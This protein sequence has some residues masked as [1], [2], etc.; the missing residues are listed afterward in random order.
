MTVSEEPKE[1][2]GPEKVG[3][4]D[5]E[6]VRRWQIAYDHVVEP[7]EVNEMGVI[8]YGAFRPLFDVARNAL[9]ATYGYVEP[10]DL[11]R[12]NWFFPVVAYSL[13]IHGPARAGDTIEI[14]AWWHT[15]KGVRAWMGAEVYAKATGAL[16]ARG[17]TEHCFVDART[18]RPVRPDPGW[19]ICLRQ[20][21]VQSGVEIREVV[22]SREEVRIR[23]V[24][25]KRKDGAT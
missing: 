13:R 25:S 11:R 10:E 5:G 8:C 7:T 2:A 12:E 17:Y 14:R 24:N 15:L 1:A 19:L 23:A 4:V 9:F 22:T 6:T 21:Q 3:E 16:V 18:G 20:R